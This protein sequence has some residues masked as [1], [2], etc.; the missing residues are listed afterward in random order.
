MPATTISPSRLVQLCLFLMHIA[1]TM[2]LHPFLILLVMT[3]KINRKTQRNRN[4]RALNSRRR[5]FCRRPR[6]VFNMMRLDWK[7]YWVNTRNRFNQDT[8]PDGPGKVLTP[9]HKL[10]W[11]SDGHVLFD[12]HRY[13]DKYIDTK[14]I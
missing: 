3:I 12:Y 1:G 5:L 11:L 14:P 8:G 9:P 6:F 13:L 10:Y 4:V 7:P 2:P